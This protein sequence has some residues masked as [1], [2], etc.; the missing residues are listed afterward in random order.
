LRNII[1]S[2][3]KPLASSGALSFHASL[4]GLRNPR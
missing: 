4:R 1:N 3:P 2:E